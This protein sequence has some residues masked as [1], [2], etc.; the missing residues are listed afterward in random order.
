MISRRFPSI[1]V[2]ILPDD[3]GKSR[4]TLNVILSVNEGALL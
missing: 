4:Q 1:Y 3:W 2:M